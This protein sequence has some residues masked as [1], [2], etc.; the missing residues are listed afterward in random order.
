MALH[1]EASLA[2]E[3]Y[4]RVALLLVIVDW[5]WDWEANSGPRFRAPQKP[6]L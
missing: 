5:F 4:S 3:G 6:S 2:R 1:L